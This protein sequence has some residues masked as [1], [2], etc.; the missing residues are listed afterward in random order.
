MSQQR[1]IDVVKTGAKRT[2]P[3]SR[4]KLHASI[5][6][7]CLSVKAHDGEA[8]KNAAKVCD[9]VIIWIDDRSEITSQDIRHVASKHLKKYHPGAAYIYE[10]HRLTL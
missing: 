8:E 7:A 1:I 6:A 9:A 2:E 3:F 5:H 10:H 4:S